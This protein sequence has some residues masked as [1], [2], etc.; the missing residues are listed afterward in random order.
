MCAM[1]PFPY[2]RTGEAAQKQW[3]LVGGQREPPN[4]QTH[5]G[6]IQY[7]CSQDHVAGSGPG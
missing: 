6:S 3:N 7:A 2:V 4:K 5:A 1:P